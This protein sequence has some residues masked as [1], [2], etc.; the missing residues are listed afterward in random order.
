MR[1]VCMFGARKSSVDDN[2]PIIEL[3]VAWDEYCIDE[4]PE[5]FEEDCEKAKKSWGNDLAAYRMVDI[6][7]NEKELRERFK[8]GQLEGELE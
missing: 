4:N 7:I 3:M 5:G 8:N 6:N 2:E 1:I